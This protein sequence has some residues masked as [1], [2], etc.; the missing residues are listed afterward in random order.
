MGTDDLNVGSTPVVAPGTYSPVTVN[1]RD[2]MGVFFL[3]I[4]SVIL[5]IAWLRAEGRYRRLVTGAGS[6]EIKSY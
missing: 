5:L 2:T 6:A 3:G 4:L 1:N